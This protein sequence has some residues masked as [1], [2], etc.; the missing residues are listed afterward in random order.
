MA[1]LKLG[2]IVRLVREPDRELDKVQEL[3]F[4]TCQVSC[5][6]MKLYSKK[7]VHK[8]RSAAQNRDIE[9]TTIWAGLP[10]RYVW[11]FIDGPST[12]GLVPLKTRRMRLKALKKAS[13]FARLVEVESITTHVGFIPENPKEPVYISL[14]DSLKEAAKFCAENGESFWF[15]TGQETPITLLRTIEDIGAENLGINLDP[16]NLLMYGKANPVDALD[17]F[18]RYVCGVHAK[19]GEYPTNGREL[20]KEKPLG[21]G[22]VNFPVLISKLKALGYEGAL[23]IEREISGPQQIED[24]RKAR[25]FLERLC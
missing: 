9:I 12:I 13:D 8:L 6:D 23:T 1:K 10:G 16:A 25:L 24:I 4:P 11:N 17:V 20:G 21:D 19:D 14:I 5:W 7:V 15:E 18:G 22:R 3:G 2:M